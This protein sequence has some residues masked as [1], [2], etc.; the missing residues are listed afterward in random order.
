MSTSSHT[1][2]LVLPVHLQMP[3]QGTQMEEGIASGV[4]TMSTEREWKV[5]TQTMKGV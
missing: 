1:T 5:N 2:K 3:L 4:A